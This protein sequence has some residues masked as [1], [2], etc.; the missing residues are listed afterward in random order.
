[1]PGTPRVGNVVACVL[2]E[3]HGDVAEHFFRSLTTKLFDDLALD[4]YSPRLRQAFRLHLLL[5]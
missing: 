3:E 4:E 1:M 5:Q 2:G